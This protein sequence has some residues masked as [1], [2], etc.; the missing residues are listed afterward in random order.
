ME[1]LAGERLQGLVEFS[2]GQ[3]FLSE[4]DI[5][6]WLETSYAHDGQ[7]WDTLALVMS[8]TPNIQ[9]PDLPGYASPN[10]D[11]LHNVLLASRI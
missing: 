3:N 5:L 2:V 8:L 7:N 4:E 10:S 9:R 6:E 11:I 1:L